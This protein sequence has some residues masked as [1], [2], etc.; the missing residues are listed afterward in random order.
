VKRAPGLPART[1]KSVGWAKLPLTGVADGDHI[2][3]VIPPAASSA[4]ADSKLT[5]SAARVFRPLHVKIKLKDN[6]LTAAE[7]FEPEVAPASDALV[8]PSAASDS[9]STPAKKIN[10]GYVGAF[11]KTTLALDLKPDWAKPGYS[12]PPLTSAG[13]VPTL[14]VLHHTGTKIIGSALNE[15]LTQKGPHYEI[16][17]DGHVVKFVD[18]RRMA[19]HAGPGSRWHGDLGCN[20]FAIGIEIIH[21]DGQKYTEEQYASLIALLKSLVKDHGIKPHRIVAHS[22][23]RV[24]DSPGDTYL[25]SNDRARCPGIEFDWARLEGE[26]LGMIPKVGVTL[27]DADWGGYFGKYQSALVL[28]DNDG[29][30]RYG[31]KKR[32]DVS[33]T[34][35]AL[36]TDLETIG[37]PLTPNAPEPLGAVTHDFRF[38]P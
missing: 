16:D 1:S 20:K 6:E 36:Q 19:W 11:D 23:C 4:P 8:G 3:K 15:A 38:V 31:N 21:Q 37:Y 30:Q 26:R 13:A 32:S 27:G 9:G 2:L 10:H 14:I 17:L 7:T 25:L 35:A 33:G 29:D 34:I 22:D 18:D 12:T 28:G 5:S 24:H